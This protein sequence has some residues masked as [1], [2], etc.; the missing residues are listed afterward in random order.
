MISDFQL[1]GI[2]E[3]LDIAVIKKA[4]RAR[5]KQLHP[6]TTENEKLINNHFLLVEV[7]KAYQRLLSS[8]PKD[9]RENIKNESSSA[10]VSARAFSTS[11]AGMNQSMT[12][13][14]VAK[15]SDPAYV[16]Y[17]SGITIFN[18]I[19]PNEWKKEERS[20]IATEIG[21]DEKEQREAQQR[22]IDLVS[23]FPKAYYHFSV[24]ANEYPESVWVADSIEK[25]ALI[26]ARMIRYKK[27]IESF[28]SWK[29]CLAEE[30]KRYEAML[31]GK[32]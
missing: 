3:T 18:K 6:D 19:H 5:V 28:S 26:E 8:A 4:Y 9:S 29:E 16:Y 14:S 1:L 24:V 13:Q 30:K 32:R 20:V 10:T 23:L 27:I 2:E 22:V 21:T 11:H 25:M 15:H 17:K 31:S 12:S 7:C